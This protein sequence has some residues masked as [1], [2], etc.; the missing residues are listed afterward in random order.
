[1]SRKRTI[2]LALRLTM[3]LL[4]S[5]ARVRRDSVLT[6]Q[7]HRL[8]LDAAGGQLHV[9]AR[10]R[11]AH[12]QRGQAIGLQ[13]LRVHPQPHRVALLGG[14]V[15][16]GH[17]G[18][19]LQAFAQGIGDGAQFQLRAAIAGQRQ[20]EDGVRIRGGLAQY[21]WID[22]GRQA[23]HRT[24]ELVAHIAGGHVQIRTELEFDLDG[25]R[26]LTAGGG[27]V[28]DARHG[29]HRFLDGLGDLRLHDLRGRAGIGSGDRDR[30]RIHGRILANA[31][32]RQRQQ[33][34]EQ[35]EQRH[36][37]RQHRPPH[38]QGG[39]RQGLCSATVGVI[40]CNALTSTPS[41]ICCRPE[42][43]ICSPALRPSTT[44][45]AWA[46]RLPICTTRRCATPS[47]T[48]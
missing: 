32:P 46:V 13:F 26:A 10:Q 11:L 17:A 39:E 42:T 3:K 40:G 34:G 41:P 47:C 18:N 30:G 9:L 20:A 1:M 6:G 4:K 22:I 28:L 31:Q 23:A 8:A 14:L 43:T 21:G 33:A 29:V 24:G 7:L 5:S 12:V 48:T 35:D 16:G 27:Q 44:C 37:Q 38:A 45:T 25:A 15:D 36:D 2:W 19:G